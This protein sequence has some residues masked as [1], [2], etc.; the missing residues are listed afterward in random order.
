MASLNCIAKWTTFSRGYAG[1]LP[2]S[3]ISLDR[4]TIRPGSEIQDLYQLQAKM[5]DGLVAMDDNLRAIENRTIRL[6]PEQVHVI[7][8]AKAAA[9]GSATVIASAIIADAVTRVTRTEE[10][11]RRLEPRPVPRLE[12]GVAAL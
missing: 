6:E 7:G 3:G 4:A 2:R 9:I 8:E 5:K 11:I 10:G 1:R 12:G